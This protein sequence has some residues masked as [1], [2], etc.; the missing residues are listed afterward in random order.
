MTGRYKRKAL[1]KGQMSQRDARRSGVQET[2][3]PTCR[4]SGK[5]GI[6]DCGLCGGTGKIRALR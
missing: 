6:R 4:G 3:C 5:R 1:P 2:D